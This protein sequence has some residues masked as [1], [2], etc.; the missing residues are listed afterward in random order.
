MRWFLSFLLFQSLV[1]SSV[2]E[3]FLSDSGQ[4][5]SPGDSTQAQFLYHSAEETMRA[6]FPLPQGFLEIL[7]SRW[8]SGE[9]NRFEIGS[10]SG[11]GDLW[12]GRD[13]QAMDGNPSPVPLPG[14]LPLLG[15]GLTALVVARKR[16]RGRLR[17]SFPL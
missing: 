12:I 16:L 13:D 4:E 2:F 9:V 8:S 17:P 7:Q 1:C 6:G 11:E 15:T 5:G 10:G 3:S 14:A